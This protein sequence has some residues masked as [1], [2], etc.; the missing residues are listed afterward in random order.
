VKSDL[1]RAKE[2]SVKS[3][4]RT[5]GLVSVLIAAGVMSLSCGD[6]SP[7]DT[8]GGHCLDC[9]N[10]PLDVLSNLEYALNNRNTTS[11]DTVLDD[12]FVFYLAP[13][14]VLTG[15]PAQWDR[16]TETTY[17]GRLLDPN[18]EGALNVANVFVDVRTDGVQ[19]VEIQPESAPTEKWYMTTVFNEYVFKVGDDEIVSEN[20][21]KMQLT[22]RNAGT[23]QRPSW[24]LVE[25]RDMDSSNG[26]S[27]QS[28]A[29]VEPRSWGE[30][31]S[32]YKP[33]PGQV[34]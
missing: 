25:W 18:L 12:N 14:D 2:I 17:M 19:W 16:T 1:P 6:D 13:H 33:D 3:N 23:A 9:G 28:A 26:L 29:A 15:L 5:F 27:A 30:I 22:V 31:K 32:M 24:K 11:Y 7:V 10:T 8:G 4:L 21:A 20:G 34:Q